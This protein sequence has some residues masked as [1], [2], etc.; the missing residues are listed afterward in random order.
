MQL[1]FLVQAQQF[2]TTARR[3]GIRIISSGA[4]TWSSPLWSLLK[5]QYSEPKGLGPVSGK[6][7]KLRPTYSVKLVFSYVVKG[8]NVKIAAK[9][10]ASRRLCFGDTKRIMSPGPRSR[11]VSGLSRNG[12]LIPEG[13]QGLTISIQV[14]IAKASL[15]AVF[16]LLL[17]QM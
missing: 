6:S 2:C 3:L 9:F 11:K 5:W 8:M 14:T 7:R 13:G 16:L 12:P 1:I 10:R 4:Q 15:Q 17:E